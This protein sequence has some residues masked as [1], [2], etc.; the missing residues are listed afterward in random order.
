M[1]IIINMRKITLLLILAS[2]I[3]NA[4]TE[5][6]FFDSIKINYN[7]LENTTLKPNKIE[8]VG[9]YSYFCGIAVDNDGSPV[10]RDDLV[11]T[12]DLIMS[13][14]SNGQWKEI[15]NFNSF[16]LSERFECHLSISIENYLSKNLPSRNNCQ[17]IEKKS[18]E[19]KSILNAI[20]GNSTDKFIVERLCSSSNI[21]YFCGASI[22][23][24]G[25]INKTGSA[26]DTYDVILKKINRS[27]VVV[28][29]LGVFAQSLDD[30]KCHFGRSDVI[31]ESNVLD[32]AARYFSTE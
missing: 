9:K 1:D 19:R 27:W 8:H 29:D 6:A 25:F 5:K 13:K 31:L 11:E 10:K 7:Y 22:N 30:I 15:A 28:K 26:I 21:A 23:S 12:Y 20:R 17:P 14:E 2:S 16:S 4:S 3:S 32:K 24:E 18:S